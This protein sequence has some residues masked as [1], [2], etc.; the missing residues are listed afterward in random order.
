M[1][2]LLIA[3]QNP[4]KQREFLSLLH[5][6]E[7]DL[8]T[9]DRLGIRLEVDETGSTYSENAQ[10]K[11][12]AFARRS[13]LLTLADDSGLEVEA[14]DGQPGIRSSRYAPKPKATDADRRAYLL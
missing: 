13:G 8:L 12:L 1:T 11:G 9:P 4:G 10:L 5:G 3:T 2:A 7:F 6:L 14:L